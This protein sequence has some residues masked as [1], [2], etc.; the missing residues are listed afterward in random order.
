MLRSSSSKPG[1]NMVHR[2]RYRRCQMWMEPR[3]VTTAAMHSMGCHVTSSTPCAGCLLF[4]LP[5]Q[6]IRCSCWHIQVPD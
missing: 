2:S 3:V 5:A 1:A 4:M 6:G